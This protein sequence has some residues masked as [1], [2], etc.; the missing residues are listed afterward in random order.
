MHLPGIR[1]LLQRAHGGDQ[2]AMEQLL[3]LVRPHLERVAAG[4]ADPEDAAQSASDIVQETSV[5]VWEHLDQFTEGGDDAATSA[6]FLAWSGQIARNAGREARRRRSALK[7]GAG[8]RP[9]SLDAPGAATSSSGGGGQQVAAGGATPSA[10]LR[11]EEQT[12]RVE[13]ALADIADADV[14]EVLRL[15]FFEGVDLRQAAARLG[16]TY[17]QARERYHRGLEKL[18]RELQENEGG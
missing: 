16:L 18:G 9:L 3:T 6:L 4:L 10:R 7:R 14:R 15:R 8:R 11:G 12:R 17:E 5:R 13:A 1:D 2:G